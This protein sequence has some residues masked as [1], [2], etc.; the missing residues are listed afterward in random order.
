[1]ECKY[2][3]NLFVKRIQNAVEIHTNSIMERNNQVF[4]KFAKQL[5]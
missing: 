3:Y 5:R 4:K 1:M 2:N